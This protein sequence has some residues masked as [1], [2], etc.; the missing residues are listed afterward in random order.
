MKQ[1][2]HS[3]FKAAALVGAAIAAPPSLAQVNSGVQ[4]YDFCNFGGDNVQVSVGEHRSM[5][6][7][8]FRNDRISSIRVA[9]GFEVRIYED[10]NFKGEFA[11][12]DGDIRCFDQFWDDRVSSIKVV[13]QR[14]VNERQFDRRNNQTTDQRIDNQQFPRINP[15]IGKNVNGNNVSTVAF[16]TSVLQQ[17]A[18]NQWRMLAAGRKPSQF[19]EIS[20]ENNSVLLQ[21]VSSAERIRIDL[22]TKDVSIVQNNGQAQRYPI[23][24]ANADAIS[25]PTNQAS[26]II[27]STPEV[28]RL[29]Q[30]CVNYRAYT[31]GGTG[32]VRVYGLL[33]FRQFGKKPISGNLC[34]NDEA[35][36]ELQKNNQGTDVYFEIDGKTFRYAP[37]EA[38]DVF[39]NTWYRRK[40]QLLY[41]R[42]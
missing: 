25:T 41:R 2:K 14:R 24:S 18:T 9:D 31:K 19:R 6:D 1:F 22:F 28:L 27:R 11:T 36:L 30:R 8:N 16:G 42:N 29:G 23:T 37:G 3:F 26:N 34:V 17:T 7:I 20:R 10:D 32:G 33:E 35:T 12:I 5:R 40:T 13:S 39:K 15:S 21:N 38:H 4:V